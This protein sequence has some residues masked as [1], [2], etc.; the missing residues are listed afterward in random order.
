MEFLIYLAVGAG[1]GVIAGL[2]GVGGGLIIVPVLLVVFNTQGIAPEVAMHLAIGT[3]LATIVFTSISSVVAHH[4][5]G[6]VQWPVVWQM[7]PSLCIGAL[8][9][10]YVAE[11]LS[12]DSLR[13]VFS[14]FEILVG[15]YLLIAWQPSAGSSQVNG[16]RLSLAAIVIGCVSAVVGI[17]GGTMMVPFLL[18]YR[19][20][21]QE[22]VATSSAGGLFIALAGAI[23]FIVTGLNL[24]ALPSGSSGFVYWPAFIGIVTS[25][26]VFAPFGAKLAHQLPA[27]QLKR[28]FALFLLGLGFYM[29]SQG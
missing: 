9:G 8:L 2:F 4:R 5:R 18:I 19:F 13:S 26:V 20:R 28:Y 22:A 6:A 15:V 23:G 1:V 3:S 21:A 16:W 14:I 12:G 29:L 27:K 17:G 11:S 7:G 25:S 24:E 10:A